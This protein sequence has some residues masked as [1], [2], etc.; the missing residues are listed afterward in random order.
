MKA[1]MFA[2]VWFVVAV[3]WQGMSHKDTSLVRLEVFLQL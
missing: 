3:C 2:V 1:V